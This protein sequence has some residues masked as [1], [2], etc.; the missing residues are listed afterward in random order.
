MVHLGREVER[1]DPRGVT[2]VEVGITLC[3]GSDRLGVSAEAGEMERCV[4][5]RLRGMPGRAGLRGL[6]RGGCSAKVGEGD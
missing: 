3:E 4:A 5:F 1:S 2:G 6:L